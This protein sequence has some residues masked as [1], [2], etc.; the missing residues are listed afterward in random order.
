MA[1]QPRG[2]AGPAGAPGAPPPGGAGPAP[3]DP[4]AQVDQNMG[5]TQ[6]FQNKANARQSM[7]QAVMAMDEKGWKILEGIINDLKQ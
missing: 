1:V 5:A 6:D 7:W 2:A 3:G 4:T